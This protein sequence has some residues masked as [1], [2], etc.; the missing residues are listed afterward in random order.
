M[1]DKRERLMDFSF[2]PSPRG[3]DISTHHCLSILT[4]KTVSSLDLHGTR[5]P[6]G[7]PLPQGQKPLLGLLTCFP[8]PSSSRT[9][10]PLDQVF[11]TVPG[12]C[13]WSEGEAQTVGDT[14]DGVNST[15][16]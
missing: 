1:I 10:V 3:C 8:T 5:G 9:F 11:P 16:S 2:P 15:R 6:G 12:G 7:P 13:G 4:T 14:A